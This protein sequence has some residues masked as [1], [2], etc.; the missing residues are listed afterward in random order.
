MLAAPAVGELDIKPPT[1]A[2]DDPQR[3]NEGQILFGF[4]AADGP[5]RILC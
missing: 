4:T 3:R 5:G 1:T 2:V